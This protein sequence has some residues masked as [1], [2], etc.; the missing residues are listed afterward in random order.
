MTDRHDEDRIDAYLWD[1][2]APPAPEVRALEAD[3]APLRYVPR[4]EGSIAWLTSRRVLVRRAAWYALAAAVLLLV[5]GAAIWTWRLSWPEGRP[6]AARAAAATAPASLAVGIPLTLAAGDRAV[7]D[8]ARIGQMAVRGDARLTLLSTQGS[9]HRLTLDKGSAHVRV[10]APPMSVVIRTPA[11]EVIDL[12]CEFEVSVEPDRTTVRVRSGWVQIEN[13][14]GET[15]VPA[16]AT[17]ESRPDRPPAVPVFDDATAAFIA[18]VRALESGAATP[19]AAVQTIAAEARV[20]DVYTLLLLVARGT[21]GSDAILARAA[22]LS[23]PP[24]DVTVNGI[25][26]G[27]RASLWRWSDSLPLPPTKSWLRNWRDGL[28]AWIAGELR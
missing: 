27:D 23:P 8:V 24:R 3:L 10:W 4:P 21:P 5:T 2:K 14:H 9:R 1:P 7:F 17:A 28:P 13:G 25:L 26:R 11:G 22:E 18:A 15:L 16:G 12:G 20:R 6:W 19:A